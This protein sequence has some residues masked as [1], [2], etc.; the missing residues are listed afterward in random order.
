VSNAEMLRE[1]AAAI[2]KHAPAGANTKEWKY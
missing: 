1:M 2:T